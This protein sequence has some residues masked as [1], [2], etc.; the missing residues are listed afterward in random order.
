MEKCHFLSSTA[1][2]LNY[3]NF[4]C[5]TSDE[6][7]LE[8]L[9]NVKL[10][11]ISEQDPQRKLHHSLTKAFAVAVDGIDVQCHEYSENYPSSP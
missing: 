11:P 10:L 9:F 4:V 2:R 5:V 6:G 1:S 3:R 8:T 7:H